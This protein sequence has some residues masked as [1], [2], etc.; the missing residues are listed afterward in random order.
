MLWRLRALRL[1]FCRLNTDLC[2]LIGL[3]SGLTSP[4][5][6]WWRK[7]YLFKDI[8]PYLL[9]SLLAECGQVFNLGWVGLGEWLKREIVQV[10]LS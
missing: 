10:N 3:P 5:G 1:S 8:G 2:G 4:A 6:R 9:R 7:P